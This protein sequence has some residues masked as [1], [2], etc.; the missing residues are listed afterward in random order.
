MSRSSGAKTFS[1]SAKPASRRISQPA[2]LLCGGDA[3][4]PNYATPWQIAAAS[5][6]NSSGRGHSLKPNDFPAALYR[7]PP[8][9]V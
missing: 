2:S 4:Q 8:A 7:V 9:P 6:F 3:L 5:W 1:R